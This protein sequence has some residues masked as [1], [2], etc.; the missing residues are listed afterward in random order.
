MYDIKTSA[1]SADIIAKVNIKT[2]FAT[3]KSN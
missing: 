1:Y 3:N 2:R